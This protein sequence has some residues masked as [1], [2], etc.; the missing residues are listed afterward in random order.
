MKKIVFFITNI[1]L[2]ALF[3]YI[4]YNNM[5]ALL[6]HNPNISHTELYYVFLSTI[7]ISI[8]IGIYLA[9]ISFVK[10]QKKLLEYERELE[11]R[12]IARDESSSRVKILENKIDVL[13]K[14][15]KE[16]LN[17]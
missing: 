8:V 2:L 3:V 12:G 11:K 17:K 7:T 9:K 4:G 5:V 14:A 16:A 1:T 6:A 10:Q 13:E 15:L